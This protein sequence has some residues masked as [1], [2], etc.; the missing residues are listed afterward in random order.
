M[1]RPRAADDF[2]AIRAPPAPLPGSTSLSGFV[3]C[4]VKAGS[5]SSS[6]VGAAEADFAS[7]SASMDHDATASGTNGLSRVRAQ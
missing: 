4:G 5:M 3:R 2:T 6:G 7:V 1:N